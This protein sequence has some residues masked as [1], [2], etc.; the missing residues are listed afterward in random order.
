MNASTIFIAMYRALECLY[1]EAPTD[2]LREYV[3]DMNPYLFKDRNSADPSIKDAF[4]Q[5]IH[6]K[7]QASLS[8]EESYQMV[9]HFL[10]DD[11]PYEPLFRKIS[12]KEWITLCR[13]VEKEESRKN[14]ASQPKPIR[15]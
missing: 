7:N 8:P 9:C 15:S 3:S 11:T 1:A 6:S 4:I 14:K 10:R 2:S 13:M 12:I 5:K